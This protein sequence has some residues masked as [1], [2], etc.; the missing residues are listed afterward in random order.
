MNMRSYF[1][2]TTLGRIRNGRSEN[3]EAAI[4]LLIQT[5]AQFL[6][7]QAAH[8]E[9]DRQCFSRIERELEAIKA[10]LIKH[11]EILQKLPEAIRDKIGF[12]Q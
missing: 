7:T 5:Q 1:G 10:L 8:E 4:A 6:Q 9:Q 3:L 11:E 12:K 2:D